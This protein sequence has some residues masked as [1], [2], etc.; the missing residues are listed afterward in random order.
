M[1]QMIYPRPE[2]H[3]QADRIALPV[4]KLAMESG[5]NGLVLTPWIG[6]PTLKRCTFCKESCFSLLWVHSSATQDGEPCRCRGFMML[7]TLRD[8]GVV[9]T[10]LILFPYGLTTERNALGWKIIGR[11]K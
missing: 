10:Q 8:G 9:Q 2:I 6:G 7:F 11:F 3:S 1:P 4:H 5:P